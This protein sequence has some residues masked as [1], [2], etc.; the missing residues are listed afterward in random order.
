MGEHHLVCIINIMAASLNGK[1][2]GESLE[3]DKARQNLGLSSPEDYAFLCNQIQQSDAII[4][5]ATSIRANGVCLGVP[6]KTGTPPLWYVLTEQGFPEDTPFWQQHQV[7]RVIVS[8]QKIPV[9]ASSGAAFL[10]VDSQE[11]IATVVYKDLEKRGF[12]RV[13]LF[14]GGVVNRWFYEKN[15]VDELKL[16]LSPLFIAGVGQP[17][18][19]DSRISKH[20]RF[21]L[22]SSQPA[23]SFVFLSYEVLKH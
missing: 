13:L 12:K 19:I 23:E 9:P 17:E 18:L 6:G 1:I 3:S 10:P 22:V 8:T 21:R 4:V 15:L 16:T 5:G 11:N 14:G 2:G 20:V 7:P